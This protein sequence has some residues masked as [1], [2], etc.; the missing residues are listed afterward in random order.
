[1]TAIFETKRNTIRKKL[2]KG[3]KLLRFQV[4]LILSQKI[5]TDVGYENE[6]VLFACSW[7]ANS[8]DNESFLMAP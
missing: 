5:E 4:Y 3:K 6:I 2:L 7:P 1:M 8:N